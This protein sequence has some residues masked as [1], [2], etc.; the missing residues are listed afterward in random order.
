MYM[1]DIVATER[2]M[3]IPWQNF[4]LDQWTSL[5]IYWEYGMSYPMGIYFRVGE[6][7]MG[8]EAEQ[9]L[10]ALDTEDGGSDA[11][12]M[13]AFCAKLK[14]VGNA[15]MFMNPSRCSMML[16]AVHPRF[17]D[18][19]HWRQELPVSCSKNAT[20]SYEQCDMDGGEGW[21]PRIELVHEFS[22]LTHLEKFE[23]DMCARGSCQD[24]SENEEDCRSRF[25]GGLVDG[26]SSVTDMQ[27]KLFSLTGFGPLQLPRRA[28]VLLFIEPCE[29]LDH[30]D[31]S[32][33]R[34]GVIVAHRFQVCTIVCQSLVVSTPLHV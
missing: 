16:F 5:N 10:G 26:C 13:A 21:S 33:R 20:T 34:L 24:S 28:S 15:V 11:A 9:D 2:E 17:D 19:A 30:A 7:G 3:D 27:N 25:W 1:S 18:G 8:N 12:H 14:M 29:E 4:P 31:V 22:L 6:A 23:N 32:N